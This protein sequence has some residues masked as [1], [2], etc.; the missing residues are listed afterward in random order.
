VPPVKSCRSGNL[1]ESPSSK[2]RNSY[3][4]GTVRRKILLGGRVVYVR[5]LTN[6]N[7]L[8]TSKGE[9]FNGFPGT[10]AA[11]APGVLSSAIR[12]RTLRLCCKFTN[13]S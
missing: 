7:G 6:D 9:K 5:Y 3:V 1:R 12:L 4:L 2:R 11:R 13:L 8:I 10:A